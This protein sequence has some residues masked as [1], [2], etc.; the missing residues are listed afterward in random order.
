[1]N[2]RTQSQNARAKAFTLVELLVSL[3]II[4]LLAALLAAALPA[5]MKRVR[6]HSC[7]TNLRSLAVGLLNY[8]SDH[9]ARVPGANRPN[10]GLASLS[11]Y[12]STPKIL[13]CSSDNQIMGT[14]DKAR[15]VATRFS[16]LQLTNVSYF[17]SGHREYGSSAVLAGDRNFGESWSGR[18]PYYPLAPGIHAI[19]TNALYGWYRFVHEQKGN[20]AMADGSVRL[21]KSEEANLTFRNQPLWPGN[22]VTF[23]A[24]DPSTSIRWP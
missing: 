7:S 20:F 21:T 13:V 10:S 22:K 14:T 12:L 24:P 3:A 2:P 4:G 15:G 17:Y 6:I 1:M 5:A 11:N 23:I 8:S 9:N 19:V 16:G 18:T